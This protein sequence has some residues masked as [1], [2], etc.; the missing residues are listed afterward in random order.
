MKGGKKMKAWKKRLSA[1]FAVT[2]VLSVAMLL[3]SC[4]PDAPTG[5]DDSTPTGDNGKVEPAIEQVTLNFSDGATTTA[6]LEGTKKVLVHSQSNYLLIEGSGYSVKVGGE[7]QKPDGDGKL[8][9]ENTA[10]TYTS[11]ELEITVTQKTTLR[12]TLVYNPGTEGN[13]YVVAQGESKTIEYTEDVH[14]SVQTG[15]YT[16]TGADP[17]V[18]TNYELDESGLVYLVEGTY[19]VGA[20]NKSKAT[21][22]TIAPAEAPA[23][24]SVENPMDISALGKSEQKLYKDVTVYFRFTAPEGGLYIFELGDDGKSAN[25]RF[26]VSAD[27]YK[28]Y[29]GR[30]NEDDDWKYYEAG[31]T[32]AAKLAKGEQI[33]VAVDFTLGAYMVGEES[34]GINI[35]VPTE[36]TK[37]DSAVKA[38]L[39]QR[40]QVYFAF[41]AQTKG[42]YTFMLRGSGT[43]IENCLIAASKLDGETLDYCGYGESVQLRLE[44]GET[45][46]VIVK[47]K[48]NEAGDIGVAV[49]KSNDEPLPENAWPAGFYT[50]S[51]TFEFELYRDTKTMVFRSEESAVTYLDGVISA[52]FGGKDY[53]FYINDEGKYVVEYT[54]TV[55]DFGDD[56]G[57]GDPDDDGYTEDEDDDGEIPTTT[58]TVVRELTYSPFPAFDTELKDFVGVYENANGDR[59]YIFDQTGD[60][61]FGMYRYT[62]NEI[63]FNEKKNLLLWGTNGVTIK[64]VKLENGRVG[65][66]NVTSY[67]EETV[68]F[69]RVNETPVKPD[70]ELPETVTG[71]YYYG[72]NGYKMVNGQLNSATV[73]I[74]GT[75]DGGYLVS[76]CDTDFNR[77]IMQMLISEDLQTITL[78]DTKGN[79]INTLSTSG[80]STGG[81]GGEEDPVDKTHVGEYVT[82]D[83]VLSLYWDGATVTYNKG[84]TSLSNGKITPNISDDGVYTFTYDRGEITVTFRFTEDGNVSLTDSKLGTFT[85]IKQA[86]GD[87]TGGEVAG[88]VVVEKNENGVPY[89]GKENV[90]AWK[91]VDVAAGIYQETYLCVKQTGWYTFKGDNNCEI[92]IRLT[93]LDIAKVFGD[94]QR[95]IKLSDE[96]VTVYL[97]KDEVIAFINS[98][99]LYADYSETN[100]DA[101]KVVIGSEENPLV[102]DG[103]DLALDVYRKKDT[104]LLYITFTATK[105]GSYKFTVTNG[106]KDDARAYLVYDGKT[107]GRTWNE[108]EFGWEK[109][110]DLPLT[111]VLTEGQTITFAVA[112]GQSGIE[113]WSLICTKP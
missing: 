73:H 88:N 65:T 99:I 64:A 61:V 11:L 95:H 93:S 86:G 84:N 67:G 37:F 51:K 46:Y 53:K 16:I 97:E 105:T 103:T 47:G 85:L 23:G 26:A 10:D 81:D 28:T 74:L 62:G 54:E 52:N 76:A 109:A 15:W 101:G 68:V 77:S 19:G 41:T 79:T 60:G 49:Q 4:T 108:D 17:F 113:G 45:A 38:T 70:E 30:Y 1:I 33:T 55:Y 111:I 98:A 43:A 112:N 35:S 14:F 69:T 13:P 56:D 6:E 82:A 59:L 94:K 32:Y 2:V 5:N 91:M 29:Y 27:G 12:F 78:L 71:N 106:T 110:N 80:E 63:S 3:A 104:S 72:E 75:I 31:T 66:V 21:S 9:I 89:L 102:W 25:G 90:P 87:E 44:A 39:R 22:V 83:D 18:L 92:F 7:E 20:D 8:Q 36:I 24:Y 107:Y 50:Y 48:K 58:K 40:G 96:E 100:P 57:W 42:S 34:I